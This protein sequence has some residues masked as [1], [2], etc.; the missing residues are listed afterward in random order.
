MKN[1]YIQAFEDAMIQ[2][3][4]IP[5][6]R[7]GDTVNLGVEIKDNIYKIRIKNSDNNKGK[8]GGYRVV[9]YIINE[10]KNIVLV[11]IYSKSK[12]NNII[13]VNLDKLIEE[14]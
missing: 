4:K 12:Q 9:T 8:S 5:Q 3:I 1:K 6:F 14:I 11:T 2:D 10:E 7:A 13:D